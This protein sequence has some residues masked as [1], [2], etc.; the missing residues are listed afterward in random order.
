MYP[1]LGNPVHISFA[2]ST[3]GWFVTDRGEILRY[4]PIVAV[5]SISKGP[6]TFIPEHFVLSQ[7]YPNPFNPTTVISYQ[8]PV[9]SNVKI[10]VFDILGREVASLVNE[11]EEAGSHEVRFDGS[12]LASGVYLYRLEAGSFV[13]TK[14]LILLK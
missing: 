3:S 13:Q 11:R 14:K 12:D 1:F 8:L 4:R 5:T 2:D 7:N 6:P 9:A 10:A